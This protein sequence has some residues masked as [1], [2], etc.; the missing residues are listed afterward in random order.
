MSEIKAVSPLMDGFEVGAPMDSHSG[1]V[2]YQATHTATKEKY[3]L[4]RISIPE[5]SSQ[6]EALLLTGACANEGEVKAYYQHVARELRTELELQ[7]QL[8]QR[9]GFA[10]FCGYQVEPKED[11]IG[12]NIYILSTFQVTL[13]AYAKKNALTH[14]NAVNLGID[15]TV[16][17]S[18]CHQAG[19]LYQDLKPEN[20]F[21][22]SQRQFQIGDLGF[23]PLDSLKYATFPDKYLSPCTAPEVQDFMSG[24]NATVDIYALGM[25]LY[26]VYNDCKYPFE[27]ACSVEEA[28]K[29]RLSGEKFSRPVYADYELSAIILKACAFN[30][31]D[32]WLTP[33]EMGQ[34][35]IS[36]MQRNA[37]NDSLIGLPR[38]E[39][40]KEQNAADAAEQEET[41]TPQPEAAE[42]TTAEET[43]AEE[44][45]ASSAPIASAP[46]EPEPVNSMPVEDRTDKMEKLAD[47]PTPDTA[48]RLEKTDEILFTEEIKQASQEESEPERE[49][50]AEPPVTTRRRR[51]AE[52]ET[53]EERKARRAREK[54]EAKADRKARKEAER[55]NGKEKKTGWLPALVMLLVT[56]VLAAVGYVFYAYYYCIPVSN[57]RITADKTD[58]MQVSFQTKAEDKDI[59]VVCTNTYGSTRSAIPV[60][61][62]V[63]FDNLRPGTQY[64]ITLNVAG[65]HKL[66]GSTVASY[67]TE[68]V[69]KVISMSAVVGSENGSIIL[70]F[71]PDGPES[72]S[73]VVLYNEEGKE[74]EQKKSVITGHSGTIFGL[75]VVKTYTFRLADKNGNLLLGD[76]ELTYKAATVL[77][78]K[79]LRLTDCTGTSFT[80]V[81]EQPQPSVE[82]WTVRCYCPDS[83]Y[84]VTQEVV[85]C[86]ATFHDLDPTCG[87][88]VEVTAAGMTKAVNVSLSANPIVITDHAYSVTNQG[89]LAVSWEF[90]G[91]PPSGWIV[92][93]TTSDAPDTPVSKTV[94]ENSII[95][96]P[97]LPGVSYSFHLQTADNGTVSNASFTIEGQ[98]AGDF[99]DYNISPSVMYLFL[100]ET[101]AYEG[102]QSRWISAGSQ[103]VFTTAQDLSFVLL[104]PANYWG[105]SQTYKAMYVLKDSQG[106]VIDT[107]VETVNW[108]TMWQQRHFTGSMP[109]I[110]EPGD[111]TLEIYFDSRFVK[112]CEFTL[113]NPA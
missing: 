79:N 12:Y 55:L 38:V 92:T 11:G 2:C 110:S 46:V 102:W 39:I 111:Y 75:T 65:F 106:K 96:G 18:D 72:E 26:W 97:A 17:L 34:A 7:Q 16:A 90:E 45:A 24:L 64:T 89:E 85:G 100:M 104:A 29:R 60:N 62:V 27:D 80:A 82:R 91:Y 14:L 32:R 6:V 113:V 78:A 43:T 86:T 15:L 71:T 67:T 36:Y 33:G 53:R 22:N 8:V 87:Y 4:K 31:E 76:N 21:I 54:A 9:S 66:T 93:Y 51:T 98:G 61:G 95:I 19:Y 73:W 40:K 69:A 28:R 81:W 35:L 84:S 1:V 101:P 20:I 37:V 105:G 41:D 107:T 57:L 47:L 112:S 3:V 88:V 44:T 59:L 83:D 58:C 68:N 5:S 52:K 108:E 77:V 13:A 56:V 63:T 109:S 50:V 10:P 42:E 74:A 30:P 99:T 103:T 48:V 49:A 23:V 25:V 94:T 70:S